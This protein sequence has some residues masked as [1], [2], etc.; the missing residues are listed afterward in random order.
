M[1]KDGE[2]KEKMVKETKEG[3]GDKFKEVVKT[4]GESLGEQREAQTEKQMKRAGNVIKD[5]NQN[6]DKYDSD[7]GEQKVKNAIKTVKQIT[8]QNPGTTTHLSEK[9]I[10]KAIDNLE[11]VPEH[12][13]GDGTLDAENSHPY[14][15]LL[16]G[17]EKEKL[18][19]F[20][21]ANK[22]QKELVAE[23][24]KK[25]DAAAKMVGSADVD[26]TTKKVM[27]SSLKIFIHWAVLTD[28]TKD[29]V[30]AG[31]EAALKSLEKWSKYASPTLKN[32]WTGEKLIE[33]A[34]FWKN[35]DSHKVEN[36][37]AMHGV[38]T[39]INAY[40]ASPAANDIT[41]DEQASLRDTAKT[42]KHKA[43]EFNTGMPDKFGT[44][45]VKV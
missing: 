24:E 45:P 23:L 21:D 39:A 32:K 15:K 33:Q 28:K 1:V 31:P 30:K 6:P 34:D 29:G 19:E 11:K 18:Q 17:S 13:E 35:K 44:Q 27:T 7:K 41:E 40:L 38:A 16:S 3:D 14:E 4:F 25:L 42:L 37:W 5:V 12:D 2:V 20:K 26:D 9:D 36:V 22:D 43:F 10:Q 8:K